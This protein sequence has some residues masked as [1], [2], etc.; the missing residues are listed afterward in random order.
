MV[1]DSDGA[2]KLLQGVAQVFEQSHYDLYLQYQNRRHA[3]GNMA[4]STTDEYMDFLGSSWCTTQ[5]VEF[6][7][8]EKLIAVAVVDRL[9]NALS[10]VYTFF[11]PEFSDF[12][13][14]VYAVLWQIEWAKQ[15]KLD[16]LYLGFWIKNCKKMSYKTEYHPFQ[17]LI[18]N[19]WL[20]INRG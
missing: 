2:Q 17:I 8:A 11:D 13:P 3:G 16:W 1:S 15:L 20:D 12:S 14:G 7:R 6:S 19:R 9:P 4:E 5:F 18:D 10:A